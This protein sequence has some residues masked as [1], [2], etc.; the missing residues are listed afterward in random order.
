MHDN[1]LLVEARIDRFMRERLVPAAWH[2]AVHLDIA[3]WQ[4]PGEPVPFAEAVTQPFACFSAGTSWGAPWGTTWF[5]I[6][7]TVP[8]E[9][10]SYGAMEARPEVLIDLGFTSLMPGFQAEALVYSAEGRVIKAIEPLNTWIPVDALLPEGAGG[11]AFEFYLEAAS[12]PNVIEGFDYA[13]TPLGSLST[14]GAGP[15]YTFRSADLALLDVPVWELI[16]DFWTL[17]GLMHELPVGLPRRHEILRALEAAVNVVDPEDVS[18]SAQAG[19]AAVAAVL[20]SPAYASAHRLHAVGHAHIDS[21][22]LWPTRETVRKVARTFSNVVD[23]MDRDPDFVFTASSAQQYAWLKEFY[24]ELFLR[25]AD[26]V[27]SGRFVPAGGM[28]VE[29]DTNMPGGE[30]L[31]R[32][33]VA[34]KRFFLENFGIEPLDVWLP[35][36]FGYSAAL[37]QIVKAA[38]SRWFLTQKISWNETNLFPHHTFRWEGI[39]GTTVFTHFPPVDTYNSQLAGRELAHAQSMYREKGAAN[40]SLVPF[41]WGDGGGGPTR[42]MLAAAHRTASLEGSPTVTLSST[43]R[44]FETAEA[45]YPDAPVW[46]GELYLELH[47]GTFT[48][49]AKTK[50]GNRRS[51]HL[52][53]EAELWCTAAALRADGSYPYAELEEAWHTVLLQQFH[54]ILPGSSIAW[55]H[56]EA[57]RRYAEVEAALEEL[58]ETALRSLLPPGAASMSL[59]AGPYE[60]DGVPAFGGGTPAQGGAQLTEQD[61]NWVLESAHLRLTVDSAG[62]FVSLIS[63]PSGREVL[64]AGMEGNVFQLFR[65]TPNQWDAWDI[66]EHY[67]F[68]KAEL[69]ATDPIQAV[70]ASLHIERSFGKSRIVEDIRLSGDG[71][72]VDIS[73]RIDWHEQ[74]KLLKLAFPLDVLADSAASEI[75]FGHVFRSTHN[76]TSWDSAKFETVAHRWVHVGEPGFGVVVANDSTYGHDISRVQAPDGGSFTLARMSLLRGPLFPDPDADQGAHSFDFSLRP[77][78]GIPDA[79]AAGYRLNLPLREL[80]GVDRT[81]LAP[82]LTVDNPAI[83]VEA[84]KLAED[85]SGDVIVRLYEAHGTRAKA[86]LAPDFDYSAVLVADLLER[87][88]G[89]LDGSSEGVALLLRPFQLMTLRFARSR[90]RPA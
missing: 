1:R 47:R 18:G 9:W 33:F 69:P 36:S 35:D 34:G 30:A 43:S 83:V 88:T 48:S 23:L 29:S 72:A 90:P 70:G 63:L 87:R 52:L 16:Q 73:L 45:E 7:G 31:A 12:N 19:R 50:K 61:G 15:L 24:P 67:R 26:K 76:N 74:Q 78:S 42:E 20:A 8:E 85:R 4:C 38:G 89:E 41:G 10:A 79:V 75:Q 13:P 66:D 5:R 22:W 28:W 77:N 82:L 39:D 3:A 81:V 60:V 65:D 40:T 14:A 46:S 17:H 21:A 49:Q 86:I 25:V 51:E 37:P 6:T 2:S 57:E 68:T 55:V 53:R 62:H 58:I 64:P 84:V 71:T 80:E 32:Q 56:E 59:N 54:D 44:F 27:R 11:R